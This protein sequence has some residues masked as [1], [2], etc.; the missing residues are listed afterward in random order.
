M[1]VW[2]ARLRSRGWELFLMTIPCFPRFCRDL[3]VI[4]LCLGGICSRA[5]AIDAAVIINEIHYHPVAGDTEWIEL[6][7][8]SGV[9]IDMSGWRL[10]DGV[11]FTFPS[12]AKIVGH[13]YLLVAANPSAASLSG[14]GA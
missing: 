4:L 8:L 14:L 3:L 9:D 7:S 10:K 11:E 13:G 12:T 6:H 2:Q 1:H 5:M